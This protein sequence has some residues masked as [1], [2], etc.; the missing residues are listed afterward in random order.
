[1]SVAVL[2][3]HNLPSSLEINNMQEAINKEFSPKSNNELQGKAPLYY[4]PIPPYSPADR[5]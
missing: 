2:S 4:N 5:V 1:M 3:S